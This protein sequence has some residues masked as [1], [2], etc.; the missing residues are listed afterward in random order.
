[1]EKTMWGNPTSSYFSI[2]CAKKE[3]VEDFIEHGSVKFGTPSEWVQEAKE[4]GE[5]R[6]DSL[7]GLIATYWYLDIENMKKIEDYFA[8]LKII[9][10]NVDGRIYLKNERSMDLPCFCIYR[11][12]VSAFDCPD[13]TGMQKISG[14][15]PKEYFQTF[16][17][18]IT[19]SYADGLNDK[20]KP[21]FYLI[22]DY[23][24]FFRRVKK[25]MTDRGVKAQDVICSPVKF[26]NLEQYEKYGWWMCKSKSPRELFWKR[27]KFAL[28]SEAR[29]IINTD[30]LHI[31]KLLKE[32]PIELG[33]ME[34]IAVP[35]YKYLYD[36]MRVEMKVD[37]GKD[38]R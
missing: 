6:G 22:K 2:H 28:Q 21:A 34:D 20:E 4:K 31:K 8:D 30:D 15:V 3:Y 14:D 13:S 27:D 19:P 9:R 7:E 25:Y 29:I 26:Y 16:A 24:E 11:M 32:G 38:N 33:N 36:G 35:V 18:N 17:D 10:N 5:G 1:M 12:P 37:V 23:D